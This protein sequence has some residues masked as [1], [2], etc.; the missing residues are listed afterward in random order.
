MRIVTRPIE[1][2]VFDHE[3]RTVRKGL[4]MVKVLN[5]GEVRDTGRQVRHIKPGMILNRCNEV[6]K[7]HDGFIPR[8][9]QVLFDGGNVAINS[10][11]SSILNFLLGFSGIQCFNGSDFTISIGGV[12]ALSRMLR[13]ST[14]V[15][16][17]LLFRARTTS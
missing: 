7:L 11:D 16:A 6:A 1:R 12:F 2:H 3:F 17:L 4:S 14:N 8:L 13:L 5:R 9:E 15:D 10:F